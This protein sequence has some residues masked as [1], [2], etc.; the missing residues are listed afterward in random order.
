MS[1]TMSP[2]MSPTALVRRQTLN[3]TIT[4]QHSSVDGEVAANHEGAHCCVLLSQTV[5]LVCE[6][7]LVLPAINEYET[8]EAGGA[9]VSLV[10]GVSPPSAAAEAWGLC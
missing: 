9:A 2:P 7:G 10:E 8:G 6:I 4:C 1:P 5:R 3:D